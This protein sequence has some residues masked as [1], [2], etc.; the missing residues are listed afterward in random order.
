MTCCA[1]GQESVSNTS[2]RAA[3]IEALTIS[4]SLL[5]HENDL[6][7]LLVV[8]ANESVKPLVLIPGYEG[9]VMKQGRVALK[10][11]FM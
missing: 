11:W 10:R 2:K 5:L 1:G 8:D 4:S 7:N 9:T 3:E 6:H